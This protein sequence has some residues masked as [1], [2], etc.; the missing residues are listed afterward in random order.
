MN[1]SETNHSYRRFFIDPENIKDGIANI[2][3][4]DANHLKNVL[5]MK[6]KDAV[7]LFD[8]QGLIHSAQI[9][10]IQH[11]EIILEIFETNKEPERIPQ[12]ILAQS[13]LKE[14]KLDALIRQLT[15]L[16]VSKII[17]FFSERSIPNPDSKK[18]Q[19][20]HDRWNKIALE[21]LKQCQ[22]NLLP[23]ISIPMSFNETIRIGQECDVKIIFWENETSPLK[24]TLS[25]CTP[26]PKK[27]I[28]LLGPEGGFSTKEIDIATGSDFITC[29]LGPRI[30]K[31]ETASIAA[32]TLL[33]FFFGDMG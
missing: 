14:K 31:A 7:T 21:S 3:G 8:G 28:I 25:T 15:E 1:N 27:I 20:R 12:I 33:Q 26:N 18:I 5:R 22:R 9:R 23:E 19:N 2:K 30:L 29:S 11:D 6:K 24:K 13:F 32:M 17:P 10:E 16:G 4:S